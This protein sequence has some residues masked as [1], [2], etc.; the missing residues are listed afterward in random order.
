MDSEVYLR[1]ATRPEPLECAGETTTNKPD[2]NK[3]AIMF[4]YV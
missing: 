3:F 4:V 1:G 2:L